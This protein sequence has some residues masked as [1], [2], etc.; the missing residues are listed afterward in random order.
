MVNQ[1]K[2][3]G[4]T[5]HV[6]TAVVSNDG[7]VKL[8]GKLKKH[9]TNPVVQVV[10]ENN[11]QGDYDINAKWPLNVPAMFTCLFN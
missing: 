11:K 3:K 2:K 1:A 8:K 6:I 5:Q 7:Q 10:F 4:A 9:A